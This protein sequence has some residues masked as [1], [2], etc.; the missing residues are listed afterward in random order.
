[1]F[2]LPD[3]ITLYSG[4]NEKVAVVVDVGVATFPCNLA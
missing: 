2:W 4:T 3:G 1:M